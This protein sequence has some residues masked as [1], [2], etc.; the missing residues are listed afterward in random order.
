VVRLNP[1]EEHGQGYGVTT[2]AGYIKHHHGDKWLIDDGELIVA[3]RASTAMYEAIKKHEAARAAILAGRLPAIEATEWLNSDHAP[4]WES[5]RGKVVLV[6]FWATWCG[7]C[8]AKLPD[9][10]RLHEKYQDQGLVVIGIHSLQDA[11]TCAAFLK[12]NGYTFPVALDSGKT[13]DGFAISGW[14][15]YFLIDRTG[16]VAQGFSHEPP[17]DDSIEA[18]LSGMEP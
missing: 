15:S 5:L 1:T 6:D 9:S 13:A 11:D 3:N 16:K 4:T 7:P 8:V 2:S 14:P 10:Q 12:E 18:L 17:S